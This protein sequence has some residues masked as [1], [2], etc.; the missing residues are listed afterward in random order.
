MGL[1]MSSLTL[2]E[3]YWDNAAKSI[4]ESYYV[5]SNGL[6]DGLYERYDING[7]LVIRIS[8]AGGEYHGLYES[9]YR[10]GTRCEYREYVRGQV[11]GEDCSW[12]NKGYPVRFMYRV[13]GL[14]QP[15]VTV[16]YKHLSEPLEVVLITLRD[17][18]G[19][20]GGVFLGRVI[21][22]LVEEGKEY[23][24]RYFNWSF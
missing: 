17:D 13:I 22:S 8:Y 11:Q 16:L 9:W 14:N 7:E 19:I 6:R 1:S 21:S 12:D 20:G 10:D 15:E 5:N 18:I 3:E 2:I 23:D 4:R 24:I